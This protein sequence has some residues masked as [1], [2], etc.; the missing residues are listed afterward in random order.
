[1]LLI[2]SWSRLVDV[3]VG[4]IGAAGAVMDGAETEAPPPPPPGTSTFTI[5]FT[6]A[7]PVAIT[8]A[9]LAIFAITSKGDGKVDFC[10]IASDAPWYVLINAVAIP[11]ALPT[12]VCFPTILVNAVI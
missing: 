1:M 11:K 6:V 9:T 10:F 7:K 4:A 12:I 3:W 8:A 5:A 2:V